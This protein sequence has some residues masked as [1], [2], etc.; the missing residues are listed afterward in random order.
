LEWASVVR[1]ATAKERLKKGEY[2]KKLATWILWCYLET[3]FRV[4]SAR[5]D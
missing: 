3:V 1:E 4:F 2:E 5:L